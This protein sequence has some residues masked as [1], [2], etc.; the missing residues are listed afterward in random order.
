MAT[1]KQSLEKQE[2]YNHQGIG[3]VEVVSSRTQET[4][5]DIAAYNA[6]LPPES[7]SQFHKAHIK[8]QSQ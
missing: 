8:S 2:I 4:L 3:N 1:S 5:L 6:Q 7:R